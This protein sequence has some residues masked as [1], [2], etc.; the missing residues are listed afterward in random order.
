M[1]ELVRK[2]KIDPSDIGFITLKNESKFKDITV[3]E[4]SLLKSHNFKIDGVERGKKPGIFSRGGVT[5][6]K[7]LER[8]IIIIIN[9]LDIQNLDINSLYVALSRAKLQFIILA[10]SKEIDA[11]KNKIGLNPPNDMYRVKYKGIRREMQHGIGD[12]K[13]LK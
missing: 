3:Q 10:Q 8:D 4:S 1:N 6:W 12:L 2:E 9:I 13:I 7:G 11:L 5:Y